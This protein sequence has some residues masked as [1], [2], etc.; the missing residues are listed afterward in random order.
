MKYL[1][2]EFMELLPD[3]IVMLLL[4]AAIV[5]GVLIFSGAI[6]FLGELVLGGST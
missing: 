2:R 5:I 6:V 1:I 4:M 3:V